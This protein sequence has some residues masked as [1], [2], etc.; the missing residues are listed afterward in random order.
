MPPQHGPGVSSPGWGPL[1]G[2]C[3]F[4]GR[5]QSWLCN[6]PPTPN[7]GS[8]RPP[9]AAGSLVE[10][11]DCYLSHL[12]LP[13]V[14]QQGLSRQCECARHWQCMLL[15]AVCL[16]RDQVPAGP[17]ERPVWAR[18]DLLP[19][20]AGHCGGGTGRAGVAAAAWQPQC[21]ASREGRTVPICLPRAITPTPAG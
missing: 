5:V 15:P 21:S 1:L 8:G 18:P 16:A 4:Q 20:T 7:Q 10:A 14:L 19:V 9:G 12:A 2:C 17:G 6:I 13:R 3:P 11:E